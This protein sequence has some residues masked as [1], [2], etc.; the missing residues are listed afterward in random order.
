MINDVCVEDTE[1]LK[2]KSK[3]E[4]VKTERGDSDSENNENNCQKAPAERSLNLCDNTG[5]DRRAFQPKESEKSKKESQSNNGHESY[6]EEDSFVSAR[7][8][9]DLPTNG[10]PT[11]IFGN[12]YKANDSLNYETVD[13]KSEVKTNVS[14]VSPVANEEVSEN[15][16]EEYDIDSPFEESLVSKDKEFIELTSNENG[17]CMQVTSHENSDNAVN[18]TKTTGTNFI[19]EQIGLEGGDDIITDADKDSVRGN[20]E[21]TLNELID[22]PAKTIDLSSNCQKVIDVESVPQNFPA[23][24]AKINVAAICSATHKEEA[25]NRSYSQNTVRDNNIT[26][27]VQLENQESIQASTETTIDKGEI[28]SVKH[29]EDTSNTCYFQNRDETLKEVVQC[30]Y[31]E[32]KQSNVE[33]KI[34]K[35]ENK[36]ASCTSCFQ[37]GDNN[38]IE[39]G[40]LGNQA[41]KQPTTEAVNKGAICSATCKEEVSNSLYLQ[42]QEDD[43]TEA[44]PLENL[45][46]AQPTIEAKR[47]EG[48][49]FGVPCKE[50]VVIDSYFQ[51]QDDNIADAVQPENQEPKPSVADFLVNEMSNQSVSTS[52]ISMD[53]DSN[54]CCS[55][56]T[57]DGNSSHMST[58]PQNVVTQQMLDEEER[59]EEEDKAEAEQHRNTVS[60]K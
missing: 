3:V 2:E 36:E 46:S 54:Q 25:P 12:K 11:T 52:E 49:I 31:Q 45:E 26:E 7:G 21:V 9:N 34:G 51:N 41:C 60:I 39:A 47:E 55:T 14:N 43:I 30:E 42:N 10:S 37:D 50:E 23:I 38:I 40:Y 1:I 18:H 15:F 13:S 56:S 27:V 8:E 44:V 24:E 59:Y 53:T 20:Q 35:A 48:A 57:L 32:A 29:R 58:P 28:Y 33:P 4:A 22:S 17:K 19:A 6:E 5:K 16:N